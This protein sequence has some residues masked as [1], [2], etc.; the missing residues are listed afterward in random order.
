[1][2]RLSGSPKGV[3]K[4]SCPNLSSQLFYTNLSCYYLNGFCH[5][6]LLLLLVKE[7]QLF[8]MPNSEFSTDS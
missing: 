5:F 4:V 2:T 1:M 8:G 3:R 6:E 7:W